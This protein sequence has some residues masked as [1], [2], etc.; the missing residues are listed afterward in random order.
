[1]SNLEKRSRIPY[2]PKRLPA[3]NDELAFIKNRSSDFAKRIKSLDS[4]FIFD[5]WIDKHYELR[6]Q[7]GDAAGFREGIDIDKVQALVNKSIKHLV[8]YATILKTFTFV[9]HNLGNGR[10]TRVVLQERTENGMLNVVIEGHFIKMDMCEITV[11][12]AMCSDEFRLS[13]GQFAL[14]IFGNASILKRLEK[15]KVREVCHI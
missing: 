2:N 11:I 5:V 14:E 4:H 7:F 1:M 8:G 12:T 15:G 13:D 3:I 6:R 9:N 10:A